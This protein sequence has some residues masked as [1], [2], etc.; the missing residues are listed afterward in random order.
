M[1]SQT[2]GGGL[3]GCGVALLFE[4]AAAA[5]ARIAGLAVA[6]RAAAEARAAG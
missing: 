3:G 2:H 6:A 5:E 1:T 4:R